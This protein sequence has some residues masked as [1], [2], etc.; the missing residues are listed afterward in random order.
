[1]L[2]GFEGSDCSIALSVAA[3][4][5]STRKTNAS[6]TPDGVA[7]FGTLLECPDPSCGGHGVCNK[8]VC[9]APWF[10]WGK[11]HSEGTLRWLQRRPRRVRRADGALHLWVGWGPAG[12][13]DRQVEHRPKLV[14]RCT[15]SWWRRNHHRSWIILWQENLDAATAARLAKASGKMQVV[16]GK[17]IDAED[18][19][20]VKNRNAFEVRTA[21]RMCSW[22]QGPWLSLQMQ[23]QVLRTEVRKIRCPGESE[24]NMCNAAKNQALVTCKPVSACVREFRGRDASAKARGRAVHA[25]KHLLGNGNEIS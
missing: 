14:R 25:W 10:V 2:R 21:R 12:H 5:F 15:E 9:G 1:M 17:N 16:G 6:A 22:G 11:V 18:F 7:T 24:E 3:T 23:W 13:C 20:C 8:G 4:A 19:V